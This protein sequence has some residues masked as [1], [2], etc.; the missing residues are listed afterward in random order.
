MA[1]RSVARKAAAEPDQKA[2]MLPLFDTDTNGDM[3]A[4]T[5]PRNLLRPKLL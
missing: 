1:A 5:A 3:H 4:A 2:A